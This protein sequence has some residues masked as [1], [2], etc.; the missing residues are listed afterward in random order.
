METYSTLIWK[1]IGAVAVLWIA[2]K[3]LSFFNNN[4]SAIPNQSSTP[5]TKPVTPSN[6]QA[7]TPVKS[8]QPNNVISNNTPTKVATTEKKEVFFKDSKDRER[9]LEKRKKALT[10]RARNNMVNSMV[11]EANQSQH[12]NQNVNNPTFSTP[13]ITSLVRTSPI[14]SSPNVTS[15]IVSSPAIGEL[16][17]PVPLEQQLINS[18]LSKSNPSPLVNRTLVEEKK[19]VKTLSQS[20][21]PS[22]VRKEKPAEEGLCLQTG[23]IKTIPAKISVEEDRETKRRRAIEAFELNKN[24]NL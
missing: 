12:Q 3:L 18:N 14:V 9:E 1:I 16:Y 22:R 24:K 2:Q 5:V 11:G 13:V 23:E 15:P 6:Q 4:Q 21:S 10:E 20:Q 19:P 7:E 8:I 17:N